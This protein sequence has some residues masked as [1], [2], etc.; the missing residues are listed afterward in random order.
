MLA[1]SVAVEA[2]LA[3]VSREARSPACVQQARDTGAR[4]MSYSVCKSIK[5]ELELGAGAQNAVTVTVAI[6]VLADD[7]A[8]SS[9]VEL[10][11]AV[12]RSNVHHATTIWVS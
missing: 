5:V 10:R 4:S 8:P 9:V 6:A 12:P 2:S 1:V 7:P 3:M 11:R